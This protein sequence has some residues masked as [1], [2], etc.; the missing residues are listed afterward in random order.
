[1][2]R[3]GRLDF[4][5]MNCEKGANGFMAYNNSKLYNI[6]GSNEFARRLEGSGNNII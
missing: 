4:E 1:M 2:H 6:I 5:N 3:L